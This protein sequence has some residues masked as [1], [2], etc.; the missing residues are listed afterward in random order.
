[1]NDMYVPCGR[2]R[3]RAQEV[4]NSH[5]YQVELFYTVKEMQL[6]ELNNRFNEVS[7]DLLLCVACLNPSSSFVS[8]DLA[9]LIQFAK[10]YYK[11]FSDFEFLALSDQL[12]NFVMGVRTSVKFSD[13]KGINDLAQKMV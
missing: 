6:Q 10:F 2:S 9:R 13:L 7:T 11:D 8:F 1:M 3:R 4:T 5:H 12:E